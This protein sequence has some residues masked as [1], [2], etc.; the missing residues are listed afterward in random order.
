MKLQILKSAWFCYTF[1]VQRIRNERITG[2]QSLSFWKSIGVF[3]PQD[4]ATDC[5]ETLWACFMCTESSE[6]I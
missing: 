3:D 2:R 6:Q 5:R 1:F 4:S